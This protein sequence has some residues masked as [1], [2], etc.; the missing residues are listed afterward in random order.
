M[1]MGKP[2]TV[3]PH[4]WTV[5]S[6]DAQLTVTEPKPS[7]EDA[8]LAVTAVGAVGNPPS[9]LVPICRRVDALET[10]PFESVILIRTTPS[11]A[12]A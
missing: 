3:R 9:G 1:P 5:G 6:A 10:A 8:R 7:A 4:R 2:S 12:S 11:T